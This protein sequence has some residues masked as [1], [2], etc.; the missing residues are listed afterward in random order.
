MPHDCT[1]F[2]NCWKGTA[3]IQSCGPGTHFNARYSVC[4]WPHKANC[5]VVP[6]TSTTPKP[7]QPGAFKLYINF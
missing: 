6:V 5:Q 4:D 1:K 3:F 2:A 7:I